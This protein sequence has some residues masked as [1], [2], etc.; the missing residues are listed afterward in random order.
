[1]CHVAAAAHMT[2]IIQ[3]IQEPKPRA[4]S[5][6][7]RTWSCQWDACTN[8]ILQSPP[9]LL[10]TFHL[11]KKKILDVPKHKS[12]L[13]LYHNHCE[14]IYDRVKMLLADSDWNP[15]HADW[16]M[17]GILRVSMASGMAKS[18]CNSKIRILSLPP[19]AGLSI[20]QVRWLSIYNPRLISHQFNNKSIKR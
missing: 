2:L 15:S 13:M 1:M 7:W 12:H 19:L 4:H 3:T 20:F 18:R 8:W 16:R 14:N 6:E 17:L 9:S 10:Y 11:K 5:Q